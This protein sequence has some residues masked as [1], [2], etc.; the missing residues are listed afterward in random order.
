MCIQN[1]SLKMEIRRLIW[2]QQD[3]FFQ[4]TIKQRMMQPAAPGNKAYQKFK[5]CS[6]TPSMNRIGKLAAAI[7]IISRAY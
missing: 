6:L 4:L 7:A 3:N 5:L 1:R 2:L